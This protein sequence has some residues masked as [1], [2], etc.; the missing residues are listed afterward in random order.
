MWP[1]RAFQCRGSLPSTS[2]TGQALDRLCRHLLF[3]TG[4]THRHLFEETVGALAG[5]SGLAKPA[6]SA[7]RRLCRTPLRREQWLTPR[8]SLVH[9]Q[10][11]L[12]TCSTN[13]SIGPQ[14]ELRSAGMGAIAFTALAPGPAHRPVRDQG[15]HED[16]DRRSTV[17]PLPS[18]TVAGQG[19][20]EDSSAESSSLTHRQLLARIALA[21]VSAPTSSAH[22]HSLAR[23]ASLSSTK[24][25]ARFDDLDFFQCRLTAMNSRHREHEHQHVA[26]LVE[27][28]IAAPR[29][30]SPRSLWITQEQRDWTISLSCCVPPC[31]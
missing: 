23:R 29:R 24:T 2:T 12:T 21:S 26:F 5:A 27:S 4:S 20:R 18:S 25:S 6:T 8:I 3:V 31:G 1:G 30:R 9:P 11:V 10:T 7:S 14:R 28:L 17:P 19:S 13:R 15:H 22:R 16:I